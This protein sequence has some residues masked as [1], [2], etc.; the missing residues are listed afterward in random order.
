MSN[1]T[2]TVKNEQTGATLR[3]KR[4]DETGLYVMRCKRVKGPKLREE[5]SVEV[6]QLVPRKHRRAAQKRMPE[7]MDLSL[8]HDMLGHPS[9]DQ[10]RA[11]LKYMEVKGM[12]KFEGCEGCNIG[13]GASKGVPKATQTRSRE[14]GQRW[15]IDTSG[16]F[17]ET[18]KKNKYWI[19]RVDD[20][21]GLG[22]CSF[23]PTK[24]RRSL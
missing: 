16:P 9:I 24:D 7:K 11:T 8:T 2:L 19:Q 14:P 18:L 21:T 6:G 3:V 17:T 10:V 4:Q 20:C 22:L 12:G 15:F 23:V 5:L 13:K 1:A